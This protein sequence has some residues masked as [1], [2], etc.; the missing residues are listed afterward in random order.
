MNSCKTLISSR[1]YYA[2]SSTS[3]SEEIAFD[4]HV[5]QLRAF[6]TA[7]V[8]DAVCVC[9][10]ATWMGINSKACNSVVRFKAD[11]NSE[12]KDLLLAQSVNLACLVRVTHSSRTNTKIQSKRPPTV[13]LFIFVFFKYLPLRLSFGSFV[14]IFFEWNG[15]RYMLSKRGR[16]MSQRVTCF[17]FLQI[18]PETMHQK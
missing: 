6:Q 3:I 12:H 17:L 2:F 10:D 18:C 15:N 9:Q 8:D 13:R 11:K 1:D 14:F 5:L 7:F 16:S 4:E